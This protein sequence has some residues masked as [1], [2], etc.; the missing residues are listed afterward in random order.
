M[1]NE[2]W[3]YGVMV[4]ISR[5]NGHKEIAKKHTF[6]KSEKQQMNRVFVTHSDFIIPISLQPINT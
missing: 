5:A 4:K 6:L 1:V 3:S 2:V